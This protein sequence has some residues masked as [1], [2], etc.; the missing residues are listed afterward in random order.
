MSEVVADINEALTETRD[1]GKVERPQKKFVT[2]SLFINPDNPV[3]LDFHSIPLESFRDFETALSFYEGVAGFEF[4]LPGGKMK[5]FT[6]R[7]D[8]VFAL[9]AVVGSGSGRSE[10]GII[11]V[12]N[13]DVDAGPVARH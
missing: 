8:K 5:E 3:K 2:L 10:Q 6:V 12:P 9:D 4:P 1:Q 13:M 11:E 7:A